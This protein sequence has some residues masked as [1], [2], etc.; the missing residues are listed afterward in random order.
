MHPMG[1]LPDV[2]RKVS[3]ERVTVD[4]FMGLVHVEWDPDL[5]MMPLG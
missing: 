4:R 2:E 3:G 1:D 5:A